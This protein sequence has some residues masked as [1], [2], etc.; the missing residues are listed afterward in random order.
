MTKSKKIIL[1]LCVTQHRQDVI[2][3]MNEK[4]HSSKH[5]LK[6]TAKG[7]GKDRSRTDHEGPEG[8]EV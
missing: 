1:Y 4:P 5:K 3:V 8:V 6:V 7:K 2:I